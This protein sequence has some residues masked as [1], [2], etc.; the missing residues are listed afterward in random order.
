M[1]WRLRTRN[2]LFFMFMVDSAPAP[3]RAGALYGT[4][5]WWDGLTSTQKPM[6]NR[7]DRGQW[8]EEVV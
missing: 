7:F 5:V 6:S 4:R 3:E 8:F 1:Q 2:E